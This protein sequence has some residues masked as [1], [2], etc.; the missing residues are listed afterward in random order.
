M[1]LDGSSLAAQTVTLL[2]NGTLSLTGTLLDAVNSALTLSGPALFEAQ[3]NS[4]LM[5]ASLAHFVSLTGGSLSLGAGT[6]GFS[7]DSSSTAS[8]SGGLLSTSG[9]DIT[10]TA[11]FVLARSNGRLIVA[12]SAAPL[13]SLAGG[14]SQIATAGSIFSLSGAATALD[15]VSG[16]VVGTKEPIQHQGGFL[17]MNAATAVTSRVVTVDT[18]LLQASAPLLN[19][20][21]G[22]EAQL[23]ANGNAIDLTLHAKA[24]NTAAFVALDQSRLIVNNAALVNVAG[25][26]YLQGSSNLV[27]LANGSIL[28]INNGVLLFVSGGSIVNINGALIAFTGSAGNQVNVSNSLAFV[29]IGGIPVALTGGALASNVLITGTPIKNASLGTI[30]PNKALIQV[31]GPA[32]KVTI[33][34][35]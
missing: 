23:T 9:T 4:S 25:G 34:G 22:G 33:S 20:R 5:G 21:G 18:A 35:N 12:A 29:N 17:D 7:F 13:I 32:S 11:D 6:N 10:S 15:P 3:A 31:N 8:L 16:L 26:S 30:T 28:T 14:N 19:L 2:R 27:N 24:T 1:S